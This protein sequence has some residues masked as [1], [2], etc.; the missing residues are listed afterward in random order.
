ML[1][2]ENAEDRGRKALGEFRG[3]WLDYER[4]Q[5]A[6]HQAKERERILT[7]RLLRLVLEIRRIYD[8]TAVSEMQGVLGRAQA[9]CYDLWH[10]ALFAERAGL[11]YDSDPRDERE[12]KDD[13]HIR[14]P[15]AMEED[16]RPI[17]E[18]PIPKISQMSAAWVA[19][20]AERDKDEGIVYL[21]ENLI[22]QAREGSMPS[23]RKIE[24][25]IDGRAPM[26]IR[27]DCRYWL[28]DPDIDEIEAG[29]AAVPHI[30][31]IL[32]AQAKAGSEVAKEAE[33]ALREAIEAARARQQ[34]RDN[35]KKGE[36]PNDIWGTAPRPKEPDPIEI[37]VSARLSFKLPPTEKQEQERRIR[38]IAR[39]TDIVTTNARPEPRGWYRKKLI[40]QGWKG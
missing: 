39:E 18:Q 35:W 34:K 22:R 20:Y 31:K 27:L 3:A 6:K 5:H 23:K 25:L 24:K 14:R 26:S 21:R 7:R 11:L 19:F 15:P 28:N 32:E 1:P 10:A 2:M 37:L 4:N 30:L 17:D 36:D 9:R 8:T 40:E 12:P 33:T 29:R 38:E 13:G 16:E